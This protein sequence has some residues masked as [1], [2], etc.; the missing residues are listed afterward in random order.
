MLAMPGEG[1]VQFNIYLPRD[2]VRRVK[3]AAID[4][5]LSLSAFVQQALEGHLGESE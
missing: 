1:K 5:D 2:L 3:Y 4:A